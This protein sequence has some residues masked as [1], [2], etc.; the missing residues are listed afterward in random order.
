MWLGKCYIFSSSMWY[1]YCHLLWEITHPLVNCGKETL[2]YLHNKVSRYHMLLG[3]QGRKEF[4]AKSH[5]PNALLCCMQ[6]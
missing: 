4:F 3:Q 2:H 6:Q 5:H 1:N